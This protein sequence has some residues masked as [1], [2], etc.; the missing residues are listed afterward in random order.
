MHRSLRSPAVTLSHVYDPIAIVFLPPIVLD[1]S[2]PRAHQHA[3]SCCARRWQDRATDLPCGHAPLMG[4]LIYRTWYVP[5]T[6]RCTPSLTTDVPSKPITFICLMLHTVSWR[7]VIVRLSEQPWRQN[8]VS[9]SDLTMN[10]VAYH[11]PWAVNQWYR[12]K[13]TGQCDTGTSSLSPPLATIL[14]DNGMYRD[15]HRP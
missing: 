1:T 3:H 7:V 12:F 6:S 15:S 4:N 9:A 13:P 14:T 5:L 11:R 2:R 8:L 10:T